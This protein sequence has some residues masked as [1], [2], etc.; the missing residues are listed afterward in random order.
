MRSHRAAPALPFRLLRRY[1][2]AKRYAVRNLG[3]SRD[4]TSCHALAAA[5]SG[6]A[7]ALLSAPA[8]LAK[9]RIMNQKTATGLDRVPRAL[10]YK[11]TLDCWEN[12]ARGE[13]FFAL[14]RGFFA[15]W[16]RL[17]PWQLIFWITCARLPPLAWRPR[18]CAPRG[19]A[20]A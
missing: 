3:L 6:L 14:Y 17:A 4:D 9:S 16:F 15:T 19:R 13:G 7:A 12:T 18:R 5:C 20:S 10:H 1:D 11:G 2:A 8:D